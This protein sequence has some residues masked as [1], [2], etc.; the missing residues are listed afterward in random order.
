M[1]LFYYIWGFFLYLVF[2][3]KN[4]IEYLYLE[5]NH[6]FI[7]FKR[8]FKDLGYLE[9]LFLSLFYRNGWFENSVANIFD[10]KSIFEYRRLNYPLIFFFHM[11]YGL[12]DYKFENLNLL[13][14]QYNY[15]NKN[16]IF[17]FKLNFIK[18]KFFKKTKNNFIYFLILQKLLYNRY[19][20]LCSSIYFENYSNLNTLKLNW[21]FHTFLLRSNG[22]FIIYNLNKYSDWYKY[23]FSKNK[24]NKINLVK[25]L[26]KEEINLVKEFKENKIKYLKKIIKYYNNNYSLVSNKF[27]IKYKNIYL[28]RFAFNKFNKIKI[29]SE[30]FSQLKLFYPVRFS[31]SSVTKNINYN[32]LNNFSFFFLRKTRI[33]NKSRYSRNR[34]LYRTGFYWCLWVNILLVY[35]LYFL[36]YRFTFN[37][38]Y[39]WWGVLLLA[40]STIFSRAFKYNFHNIYYLYDEFVQLIYWV[41]FIV[42]ELKLQFTNYF[43]NL[44]FKLNLINYLSSYKN[45][46]FDIILNKP[47]FYF[48]KFF[49]KWIENRNSTNFV[50]FWEGMKEK[51]SSLFRYKTIIHWFRQL[52]RMIL[53]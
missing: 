52:Y 39:L 46:K 34:Q 17:K 16:K 20:N 14:K 19:Y 50:F 21:L 51:D 49:T 22:K 7:I 31:E 36:F 3:L 32:N 27:D 42:L 28:F 11:Y 53:N 37:F 13:L 44:L 47:L 30:W 8:E 25:S 38:G 40:Y 6:P 2:K 41:G 35:G 45:Y 26:T 12:M 10:K 9:K 15:F 5:F 4:I 33:F 1:F 48:V 24:T 43:S 18:N 23:N 29:N